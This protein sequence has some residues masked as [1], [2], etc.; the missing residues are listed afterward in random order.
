MF[1]M[2]RINVYEPLGWVLK[3]QSVAVTGQMPESYCLCRGQSLVQQKHIPI[4]FVTE[5]SDALAHRRVS[6]ILHTLNGF[7]LYQLSSQLVA[8]HQ[9]VHPA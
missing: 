1:T 3:V 4:S 6:L 8:I 2:T 7:L 9:Q 5:V